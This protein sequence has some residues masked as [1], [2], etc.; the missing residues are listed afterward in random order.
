VPGTVVPITTASH[1]WMMQASAQRQVFDAQT[2]KHRCTVNIEGAAKLSAREDRR[3]GPHFVKWQ[4]FDPSI[5]GEE[6]E[7]EEVA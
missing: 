4:P 6:V 1:Q 3:Y 7:V 5:L 2:G